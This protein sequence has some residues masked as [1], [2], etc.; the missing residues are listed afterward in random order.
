MTSANQAQLRTR[1]TNALYDKSRNAIFAVDDKGLVYRM[2]SELRLVSKSANTLHGVALHGMCDDDLFIYTRDVAGNVVRW[3]KNTLNPLN[4]LLS[5]YLSDSAQEHLPPVPSPSHAIACTEDLLVVCNAR[6]CLSA[7]SRKEMTYQWAADVS[8]RAFLEHVSVDPSHADGSLLVIDVTGT[9]FR[10]NTVTQAAKPLLELRSGVSHSLR[11]DSRFD[12][13]WITSDVGG[14]ITLFSEEP[15][16]TT[17]IRFTNDDVEEI[18]LTSDASTGYV[19]CFDHHI[20]VFEND[21]VPRLT[22]RIGPFKFQVN[23]LKPMDDQR[24]LALLESGELYIIDSASGTVAAAA[25]GT[26]TY[27]DFLLDHHSLSAFS[28]SGIVDRYRLVSQFKDFAFVYEDEIHVSGTETR[29]R[30]GARL[31]RD[32]FSICTDGSA[33]RFDE[34]GLVRWKVRI[35]GI[36]RDVSVTPAQDRVVLCSE[37]GWLVE[38]AADTGEVLWRFKNKRPIWCVQYVDDGRTVVYGERELRQE[39]AA[40]T[41]SRLVFFDILTQVVVGQLPDMGNHKRLRLCDDQRLLVSGNGNNAVQIVD[42]GSRTVLNK[43]KEWQINT[44][45][46]AV[47]HGDFVYVAT[48]GY[49][50]LTYSIETGEL[51]DG[52]HVLEGY[53]GGLQLWRNEAGVPFLLLSVRNALMAFCIASGSPELVATRYLYDR[54]YRDNHARVRMQKELQAT[55]WE[56]TT[57]L[58]D[59]QPA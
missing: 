28:E 35:D 46:N 37:T 5:G 31:G 4:F 50:L 24:L 22:G 47:L 52:Q 36:L 21:L 20:Y 39:E 12:R 15:A 40:R 6:G 56:L 8:S 55:N 49:Q 30:M 26:T 54:F 57:A 1:F 59:L 14:G 42:I 43:F 53:P 33:L 25:G 7:L 34:T 2:D 44:P 16:R 10:F 38:L 11:Y 48:Y 17:H 58:E 13:Y 9:L 45:E 19:A 18:V 23:H 32:Y 27:W 3:C 29:M 41:P 51:L